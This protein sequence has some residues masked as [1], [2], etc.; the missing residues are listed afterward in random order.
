MLGI[1]DGCR[2]TNRLRRE[3]FGFVS[4]EPEAVSFSCATS[5]DVFSTPNPLRLCKTVQS[6]RTKAKS[7]QRPNREKKKPVGTCP[8]SSAFL[9]K[10][11]PPKKHQD[12]SGRD[13]D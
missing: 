1:L 12:T 8:E 10:Q 5:D 4:S 7:T 9:V 2:Q 13:P 3:T 6:V 11:G